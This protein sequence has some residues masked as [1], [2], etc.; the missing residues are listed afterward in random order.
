M[1]SLS[2][3]ILLGC[4]GVKTAPTN[5][6]A[7]VGTVDATISADGAIE[8]DAS[9]VCN[10]R[11]ALIRYN[12]QFDIFTVNQNGSKLKNLTHSAEANDVRPEWSPDGQQIAFVMNQVPTPGI[13][14]M[15]ADGSGVKLLAA[16]GGSQQ[17]SPGG[18]K[19]AF[20]RQEQIFVMNADGSGQKQLTT[21]GGNEPQWTPDGKTLVF[22][23]AR[24]NVLDIYSI[25]IDGSGETNLTLA[26]KMFDLN[27][28]VSPDGTQIVF[29]SGP[30]AQTTHI[31]EMN[32]DGSGRTSYFAG[33]TSEENPRFS[34]DGTQIVFTSGPAVMVSG[35]DGKNLITVATGN[36]PS[37]SPKGDAIAYQDGD[38]GGVG[39]ADPT[40]ANSGQA[41]TNGGSS[42]SIVWQPCTP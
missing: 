40:V 29:Q 7:A 34:P 18:K 41:I 20:T 14:V 35:T 4:G 15:N 19:I 38:K 25:N 1:A 8:I 37:W 2:G 42:A 9:M 28:R 32:L 3:V 5:T 11:L 23:A 13:F 10:T 36:F 30:T 24:N 31:T 16:R 26:N 22:H 21:A 12:T 17:W 6:D 27:P 39:I 33:G